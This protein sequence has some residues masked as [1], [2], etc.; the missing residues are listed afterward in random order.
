MESGVCGGLVDGDVLGDGIGRIWYGIEALLVFLVNSGSEWVV[1]ARRWS[2]SLLSLLLISCSAALLQ[3][4][5][6]IAWLW[7]GGSESMMN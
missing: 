7:N 6:R 3:F 1:V 5:R 2:F 4:R